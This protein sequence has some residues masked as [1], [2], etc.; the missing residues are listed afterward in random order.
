MVEQDPIMFVYNSPVGNV[1][2]YLGRK[3]KSLPIK[4]WEEF[5]NGAIGKEELRIKVEQLFNND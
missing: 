5:K 2:I 4:N 3:F 1:T